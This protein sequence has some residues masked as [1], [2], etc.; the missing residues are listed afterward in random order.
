MKIAPNNSANAGKKNFLFY[1]TN[2]VNKTFAKA[3]GN[4]N[5][6]QIDVITKEMKRAFLADA[7]PDNVGNFEQVKNNNNDDDGEFEQVSKRPRRQQ[8]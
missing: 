2:I 4:A 5:N 1:K 3:A 8:S 6:I 7:E